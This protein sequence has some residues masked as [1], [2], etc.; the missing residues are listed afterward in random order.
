VSATNL[1]ETEMFEPDATIRQVMNAVMLKWGTAAPLTELTADIG[2]NA[3]WL[4]AAEA[5]KVRK[6]AD[7]IAQAIRLIEEVE[8]ETE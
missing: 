5:E 7:L 3:K 8:K 2:W 6:A 4:P 1:K